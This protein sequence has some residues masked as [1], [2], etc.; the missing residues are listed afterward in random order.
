MPRPPAATMV[1]RDTAAHAGH[2]ARTLKERP[3]APADPTRRALPVRRHRARQCQRHLCAD[4][5]PAHGARRQAAL[6]E[7]PGA[8]R[9]PSAPQSDL[10]QPPAA[11]APRIGRPV[12]GRRRAL[13]SRVPRAPHRAAG[14]GRLAAVL[15][16]G[17]A[18]PR[19]RARPQ[20][21]AVGDLRHRRPGQRGRV[22][23]GQFRA[24]DQDPPRGAGRRAPRRDHRGAARRRAPAAPARAAG[25]VVPR[26]AAGRV[27]AAVPRCRAHAAVAHPSGR[28]AGPHGPQA[29]GVCRR[30]DGARAAGRHALQFHRLGT[31]RVR[32]AP[33]CAGRIR[34]HPRP[35]SRCDAGRRGAGRVRRWPAPLPGRARRAAGGRP[36]GR[37]ALGCA[38]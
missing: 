30:S 27:F 34:R 23:Q 28:A 20:P 36:V 33:L 11:R 31:P 35:C 32:H 4:L 14:A 29:E 25:A 9:K 6:Q 5:R 17:L 22:A 19:P 21:P 26:A 1:R 24:V 7:H 2:A 10:P 8:H 13:R 18:H 38:R 37:C 16:P 15:H 12:L 3:D